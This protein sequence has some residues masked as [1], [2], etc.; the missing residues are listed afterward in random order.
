MDDVL[1]RVRLFGFLIRNLNLK[2]FF[3]RHNNF[4]SVQRVRTQVLLEFDGGK[5]FMR[6]F[7]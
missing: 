1:H 2:L 6:L 5:N 4:E 7:L 3:N